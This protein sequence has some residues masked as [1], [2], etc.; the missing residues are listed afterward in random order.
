[1]DN[2]DVAGRRKKRARTAQHTVQSILRL[3]IVFL[4]SLNNNKCMY[5]FLLSTIAL[6]ESIIIFLLSQFR[7]STHNTAAMTNQMCANVPEINHTN[8]MEN[9]IKKKSNE[10]HII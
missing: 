7:V 4:H 2:C 1:M 6:N 10:T 8:Q 3:I 5:I 9:K